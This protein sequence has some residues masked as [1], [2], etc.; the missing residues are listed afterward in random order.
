MS[1][2]F[3]NHFSHRYELRLDQKPAKATDRISLEILYPG[4]L[5]AGVLLFI[6]LYELLNGFK[7][8]QTVFDD[9]VA[10]GD[11]S[12]HQPW[13][14]PAFFD[15]VIIAVGVGIIISLLVSY[16]RYKKIIVNDDKVE[17]VHRPFLGPKRGYVE[18][19]STYEGVRYRIEFYQFGFLNKNRYIVELYHRDPAKIVPLYISMSDK[20]VRRIWEYYA[21][22]F[23]LPTLVTTDEGLVRRN[24]EDLDKS[25]ITLAKAGK[26]KDDYDADERLP[27]GIAYVRKKDKIIL[28]A[29]KIIWDAYNFIALGALLFLLLAVAVLSFGTSFRQAFSPLELGAFYLAVGI[30]FVVAVFVLF[31]KDKLVIKKHKLVHTHKY[32]LF[33]HKNDEILKKDIE[34]IEVSVNPATGRQ[35]VAVISDAKTITFAKKV[36]LEGLRRIRKFLIHVV[37]K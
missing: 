35:C 33:S 34:A 6:G 12:L 13:F 37:I 17:I 8:P 14:S 31:R 32:L 11:V 20:H 18:K 28:K 3:P 24:V 4:L 21:K 26:V 30:V 19:I 2:N 9:L 29:R 16:V 10:S 5:F 25:L 23:N 27:A 15:V 36:P 7:H 1:A 22:A